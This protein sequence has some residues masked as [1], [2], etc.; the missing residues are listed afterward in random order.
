MSAARDLLTDLDLIGARL[1]PAGDR[2][3]LRA[4]TKAIPAGLVRRVRDAKAD[5]L[6]ALSVSAGQTALGNNRNRDRGGN[7]HESNPRIFESRVVE[8][9]NQHPSPSAP[10]RCAWCA[11]TESSS[12]IVLPFGTEPGTHTWLHSECWSAWHKARRADAVAALSATDTDLDG[13]PSNDHDR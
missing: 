9:L 12:T 2:L 5:L 13:S 7:L 3:I 8:W 10:G 6:A 4:G 1:E 11:E